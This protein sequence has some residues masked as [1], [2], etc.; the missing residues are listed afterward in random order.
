MA[1]YRKYRPATFAEVVG[2]EH[3]TV[4]LSNALASRGPDGRPDRINHAYLFS[5]PRGCGKTSS[6][7]ILARSLNCAE[8]PTATPC[9]KCDSCLALAPGGVGHLDVVELDAASHNGVE[10]MRELRDK[11]MYPPTSSRYTI[12]IIDEAHMVTNQG[13]NALLKVVEEPPEHL[14]FIFAT[15]EPEKVIPTIRSRTHHYPFRLLSPKDMRGLLERIVAEE[16]VVVD[17]QVYP[18]VIAA[19]GGSP[20]D[21]LSILDQLVAGSGPEG[22]TYELATAL[23]GVTD[24]ALLDEAVEALAGFDRAGLFACVDR[25]IDSGLDPRRFAEDLLAQIRDLM[26]MA[27]VP[28]AVSAGLVEVPGD[29]AEVLAAQAQ[30]I[31][32][33]ALTRYAEVLHRGIGEMRGAT[34]QRLLLEVLCARML[35]PGVDGNVE[36]LVQ[37]VEAL[38]RGL[39][40]PAAGAQVVR[41]DGDR[42]PSP[43]PAPAPAGEPAHGGGF[44]EEEPEAPADPGSGRRALE[45]YR[46]RR[47]AKASGGA[48]QQAQPAQQA[49]APEPQAQPEQQR[50]AEPENA[51]DGQ[52]QENAAAPDDPV[53]G[54][55]AARQAA[56]RMQEV[57]RQ[58]ER[59]ERER[60]AM[61]QERA[62]RRAEGLPEEPE[63]ASESAAPDATADPSA[64]DGHAAEQAPAA[65]AAT[66]P[67][68]SAEPAGAD[69]AEAG[70]AEPTESADPERRPQVLAEPQPEVV[71][72]PEPEPME[73]RAPEPRQEDRSPAVDVDKLRATWGDVMDAVSSDRRAARVMAAQATPLELDGDELIVGH[74]TGALANRLNAEENVAAIGAAIREVHGVDLTVRFVVGHRSGSRPRQRNAA[75]S[76]RSGESSDG[77]S[78]P[79]PRPAPGEQSAPP[80]REESRQEAPREQAAPQNAPCEEPSPQPTQPEPQQAQQQ[81]SKPAPS[82]MDAGTGG[83][84]ATPATGSGDESS[85]RPIPRWKKLAQQRRRV[86]AQEQA[87]REAEEKA[88]Q[89]AEERRRAAAATNRPAMPQRDH[90][91][92]PPPEPSWNDAPPPEPY[93]D[94]PPP[95]EPWDDAPPPEDFGGPGPSAPA[96]RA[97][98]QAPA[99]QAPQAAQRPSPRERAE[100]QA[101][102]AAQAAPAA[103]SP[104]APQAPASPEDEEREYI[105]AAHSQPG[106]LDH[107]SQREVVI[108]M[109]EKELGAR[110]M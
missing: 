75:P 60:I 62:A 56:R 70:D 59:A 36:S 77:T 20:R 4:P 82:T 71:A 7:R 46:R 92:P 48:P 28:D 52:Q 72:E 35:L 26:V 85:G 34:S 84:S 86:D 95:P 21:S 102:Q 24:Q 38:E 79:G 87:R 32:Q 18:L 50:P 10:D 97:P 8:G 89:E 12:F 110:L 105:E 80:R 88:K 41:D 37:R 17:P 101:A 2:Q 67:A 42:A 47:A 25:A 66:E 23:L 6:A 33:G 78:G 16:G 11:A 27:A 22:V 53:Q 39:P 69:R 74:H 99:Q 96:P 90:S 76:E 54:L 44:T 43:A 83:E 49:Q 19:G 98:Q 57:A 65:P 15:T 31:P 40:A 51:R 30:S 106:S 94:V 104:S 5:G 1:L 3:V 13:F 45:E 58:Q 81:P 108:E 103:P 64:H 100:Q 9:G 29:R 55:L 73:S 68:S 61:E 91:A 93:D 14:I 109:L 63:D 107:R